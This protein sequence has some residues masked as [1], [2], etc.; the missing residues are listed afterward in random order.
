[1]GKRTAKEIA[2]SGVFFTD[3]HLT[4]TTSG[5][6]LPYDAIR[7]F[8]DQ[9]EFAHHAAA[10]Q[11]LGFKLDVRRAVVGTAKHVRVRPRFETWTVSGTLEVTADEITH[12]LLVSIFEQAGRVGLGD[13]RPGAK[14]PG[15]YGMFSTNLKRID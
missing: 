12:D 15:V 7:T 4:F 2:V 9:P 3:E 6:Q 14:T 11:K 10:V 13:W 1:M 5:K 8:L